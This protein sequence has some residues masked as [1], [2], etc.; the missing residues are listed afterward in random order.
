[1]TGLSAEAFLPGKGPHIHLRP[2]DRHRKSGAGGVAEGEPLPVRRDPVP[3]RNFD[4]ARCS[5]CDVNNVVLPVDRVKIGQLSVIRP[6]NRGIEFQLLGDIRGPA[7]GKALPDQCGDRP[8]PQEAPHGG[9]EGPG[10]GRRHDPYEI[11]FGNFEDPFGVLN[12]TEQFFLPQG[13]TMGTADCRVFQ[14]IEGP[15]GSLVAG[16]G[17]EMGI[18]HETFLSQNVK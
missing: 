17:G 2:V 1:V 13:G 7:L 4:T 8:Y 9:L 10:I 14:S 15:R 12:G 6:Q 16:T 11:I 5:V 18:A 3:V